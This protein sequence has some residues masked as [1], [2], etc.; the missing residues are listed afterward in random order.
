MY[1]YAC[2]ALGMEKAPILQIF[3]SCLGREVNKGTW[4]IFIVFIYF[5]PTVWGSFVA[6]G[7]HHS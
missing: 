2:N 5:F 7:E 4:W 1:I 6:V 3:F